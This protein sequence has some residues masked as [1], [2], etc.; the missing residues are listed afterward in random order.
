M[1]PK[2]STGSSKPHS[3]RYFY[4]DTMS[5]TER[6]DFFAHPCA[7]DFDCAG[8]IRYVMFGPLERAFAPDNSPQWTAGLTQVYDANG[9]R[10]YS[11]TP[12]AN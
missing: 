4:A 11:T 3:F 9:Y 1:G 6:A 2:Q 5:A 10:I 8:T 12:P 7:P